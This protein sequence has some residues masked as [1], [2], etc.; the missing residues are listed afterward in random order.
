MTHQHLGD[1]G[2]FSLSV[3]VTSPPWYENCFVV[4]HK[5]S[6]TVAVVDPGGDAERILHAVEAMGGKPEVIL[7]THGHPD[8]LGAAHQLETALK[9]VTRAHADEMPVIEAASDLN[10]S[11]TGQPQKGPGS[12][13]TFPGEPSETLGGAPIRVIHTPG[14]T[15][16]GVC[17]DF[18]PFVLTGDTLFRNGVG[19]TDLPGGSEQKLWASINHLLGL[20]DDKVML[21]SGHGPEWSVQDARRWWRMV[22]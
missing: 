16:G 17:F 8:H 10:R 1:F 3:V 4:L 14:H 21:F 18:G 9:I 5:P 6:Q 11:F 12:L 7:L 2:D 22:G 13:E 15:P 19:R 20:L